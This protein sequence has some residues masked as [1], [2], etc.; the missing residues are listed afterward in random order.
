MTDTLQLL[1]MFSGLITMLITGTIAAGGPSE[2]YKANKI[3]GRLDV[4]EYAVLNTI[5]CNFG[6][7]YPRSSQTLLITRTVCHMY[8]RR[9]STSSGRTKFLAFSHPKKLKLH[10][11]LHR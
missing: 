11:L 7:V 3:S 10:K 4:L 9:G 6:L 2:V 5:D 8:P 1:L